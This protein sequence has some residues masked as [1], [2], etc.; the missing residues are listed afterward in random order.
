MQSVKKVGLLLLMSVA[1]ACSEQSPA[2]PAAAPGATDSGSRT[3]ESGE[4]AVLKLTPP[5]PTEPANGHT[6]PKGERPST[7]EVEAA[8]GEFAEISGV[9]HRFQVLKGNQRVIDGVV[10]TKGETASFDVRRASLAART[11]YR[12]RV[13]GENEEGVGPWSPMSTFTTGAGVQ[14]RTPD[15]QTSDPAARALLAAVGGELAAQQSGLLRDSCQKRSA[16]G[17]RFLNTLVDRLRKHDN[18]WAYNGKRGNPHDPS[19]DVIAYHYGPGP[20]ENRRDVWLYDVIIGHCGNR[21]TFAVNEVHS[22]TTPGLM[23]WIT[24]GRFSNEY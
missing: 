4:Q 12:W 15:G 2:A 13:R 9:A 22:K 19:H 11:E 18:R 8:T 1:A 16:G 20:S 17:W 5:T 7:L 23:I 21:P 14:A 6:Y 10:P 3:A 24:R